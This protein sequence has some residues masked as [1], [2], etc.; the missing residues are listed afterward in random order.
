ALLLPG[1]QMPLNIFEPRYLRMVDDALGGARMIGMIQP[2][3]AQTDGPPALY[4][5]GCAGR[6]T[7]FVETSDGRYLITLT[8]QRRFKLVREIGADTPYRIAEIDWDA[9]EIDA[10]GDDTGAAVDRDA[11]LDAMKTYLDAEGLQTDWE[12]AEAAS[13]DA[14][15]ASLAMGCPFPPNEKQALLEAATVADRA[16]CLMALMEMAAS[17]ANGDQILQ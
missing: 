2:C 15:I 8:G 16:A 9:F 3:E 1:G 5:V 17:D 7:S 6:I 10:H 12:E 11:L 13:T 4:S 14:L